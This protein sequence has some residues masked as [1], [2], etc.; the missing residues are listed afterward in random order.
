METS[1]LLGLREVLEKARIDGGIRGMSVGIL[2]KGEL[3]FAEGFGLRNEQD[4]FTAETVMPIASLTKAFT[5]AA[6]GEIVAEG[7]LDW[8][9]TPVCQYLPEFQLQDP[10]F[11]AQLTLTDLLSHRTG[12]PDLFYAWYKNTM[13]R[14][15]IIKRLKH[16]KVEPKYRSKYQYN[17]TMYAVAGEVAAEVAG[18]S[19]EDIVR[20][21]VIEP[22]GLTHTGLSPKDM[23]KKHGENYAM[24]YDASSFENALKG[25]YERGELDMQFN[26]EAA[27]GD[28]YSNVLDLVKWGRVIIKLGELDG[29][30]VLNKESLEET[31]SG[32][33]I[34]KDKR[35]SPEFAPVAVYGLG[36]V[37]DSYKGHTFYCHGGSLPGFRSNMAI[38]PDD[39]L[40]IAQL[41]N[42]NVTDLPDKVPFYVAD[43]LLGLTKT[44]DW[45]ELAVTKVQTDYEFMTNQAKGNIPKQIENKPP[46]H[47][48]EAYVGEYTDPIYGD[49]SVVFEDGQL[50]YKMRFYKSKLV[51]VHYD[52]FKMVL[53]TFGLNCG[54][55]LS[56]HTD[57][58]DGT[59]SGFQVDGGSY[60]YAPVDFMRKKSAEK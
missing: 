34:R 20:T 6:I 23:V 26:A 35:R 54:V 30:Q 11:T 43:E 57:R 38:F 2:Y 56:F 60:F 22:L 39:D 4:P 31:L 42:V 25:E 9:T 19:F 41:C 8:N 21:R 33:A 49:A 27:A 14:R 53:E 15:D 29:K 46:T 3:I 50:I 44:Q 16:L 18:M 5:T 28:V 24:P 13:S 52:S 48:L 45:L 17:N 12:A 58:R 55:L 1:R 47:T 59:V 51:H 32:R 36:H 7:K 10:N 40:V 37:I